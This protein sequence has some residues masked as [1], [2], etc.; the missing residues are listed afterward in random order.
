ML[1]TI[2]IS[3][4]RNELEKLGFIHATGLSVFNAQSDEQYEIQ[5]H[6]MDLGH[7]G[8]NN[9]WIVA[10]LENG[11]V[12]LRA[13][14]IE[15]PMSKIRN[16]LKRVCPK[17]RRA[18]VP[19]AFGDIICYFHLALRVANPYDDCGKFADPNP[20]PRRQPRS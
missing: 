3:N 17:G 14:Y 18:P 5:A 4:A 2:T 7:W 11:E 13:Y 15:N 9:S 20:K 6:I 19:L 16:I 8:Y 12:W 10:V 1:Q